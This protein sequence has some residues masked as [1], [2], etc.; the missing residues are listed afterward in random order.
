MRRGVIL[1]VA[2]FIIL[3]LLVFVFFP[4]RG[5]VV[6]PFDLSQTFTSSNGQLRVNYPI[7]WS[8]SEVGSAFFWLAS[9]GGSLLPGDPLPLESARISFALP[10][11]LRQLNVVYSPEGAETRTV[12]G[13]PAFVQRAN[14]GVFH[15]TTIV[16]TY[17]DGQLAGTLFT[18]PGDEAVLEP[19]FFSIADTIQYRPS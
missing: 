8:A 19:I 9:P 12:A 10:A 15:T 6:E 5:T 17:S 4:P 3:L 14:D 2:L 16:L 1:I 7:D 11:Q 13:L 18:N